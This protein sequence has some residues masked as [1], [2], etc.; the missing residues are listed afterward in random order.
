VSLD[1]VPT[2]HSVPFAARAVPGAAPASPATQ[3]AHLL[4]FA[5]RLLGDA[6]LA[7]E[8]TRRVLEE[9]GEDAHVSLRELERRLVFQLRAHLGELHE[10]ALDGLLPSFS[11]LGAHLAPP[12]SLAGASPARLRAGTQ[13]GFAELPPLSRAVLLLT[14]GHGLTPAE[15]ARWLALPEARVREV[16]HHARQALLTLLARA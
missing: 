3:V 8:A 16:R 13:R 14:D 7:L 10:S 9:H 2:S 15:C 5:T 1:A 12:P 11:P 4:A 6:G